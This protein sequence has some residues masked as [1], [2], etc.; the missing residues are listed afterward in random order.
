[1]TAEIAAKL[2]ARGVQEYQLE[3]TRPGG[4]TGWTVVGSCEGG[5]REILYR[6]GL[7]EP[8]P[9]LA[10]DMAPPPEDEPQGMPAEPIRPLRCVAMQQDA[11]AGAAPDGLVHRGAGQLPASRPAPLHP[12]REPRLRADAQGLRA[13][14]AL[15]I[16]VFHLWV[17]KVSGGV[18]VFFV[19][20][21]YLMAGV[22]LRQVSGGGR[23]QPVRF[24]AGVVV[25]VAPAAYL[26]LLCTVL[27]GYLYVPAP[28]WRTSIDDLLF[29]TLHLENLHLLRNGVNYLERLD[30]PGPF[31]QFWALSMQMQFYVLLPAI[32]AL[33]LRLAGRFNSRL[34][35][36]L[37]VA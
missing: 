16:L 1:L 31:Q 9:A 8:M 6:R 36:L 34:P 21:G 20:S 27:L 26:V 12:Y 33:G 25:R 24:W 35:L 5:S 37:L 14:G 29:S 22:L 10:P 13:I 15:L 7:P 4:A 3:I 32:M 19:I 18:D 30:P 23:L 28:L 11:I 17:H 2:E